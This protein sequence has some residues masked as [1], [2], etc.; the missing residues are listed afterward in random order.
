MINCNF[1]AR[2]G[3]DAEL[4]ETSKGRKFVTARAAV[5]DGGSKEK[6]TWVT[7]R[8]FAENAETMCKYLTK[9]KL[10]SI[11][12]TLNVTA[13]ISKKDESAVPSIDCN[14]SSFEF[15]N[16]SKPQEQASGEVANTADCGTLDTEKIASTAAQMLASSRAKAMATTAASTSSEEDDLPF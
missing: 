8:Y 10:L 11:A 1:V 3:A 14:V 5:N 2:L 13:Y 15:V 9:G 12:G 4:K 6:T 16:T 7:L